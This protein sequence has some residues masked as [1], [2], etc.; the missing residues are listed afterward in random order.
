MCLKLRVLENLTVFFIQKWT[1][2]RL[3]YI[4]DSGIVPWKEASIGLKN[5]Q[6]NQTMPSKKK[7]TVKTLFLFII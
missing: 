7:T 1:H 6:I 3:N 2:E 5:E 4:A